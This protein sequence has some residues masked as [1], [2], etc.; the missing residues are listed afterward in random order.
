M[1]ESV[2]NYVKEGTDHPDC[3]SSSPLP[4]GVALKNRVSML[5][6]RL[7]IAKRGSATLPQDTARPPGDFGGSSFPNAAGDHD[8]EAA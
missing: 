3:Y 2:S 6:T 5:R 8:E 1:S 4:H 7:M